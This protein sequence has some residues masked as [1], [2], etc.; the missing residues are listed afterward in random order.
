MYVKILIFVGFCERHEIVLF[1]YVVMC[2]I[3]SHKNEGHMKTDYNYSEKTLLAF[4][5]VVM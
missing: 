5:Y 2:V 4:S 3:S 1:G